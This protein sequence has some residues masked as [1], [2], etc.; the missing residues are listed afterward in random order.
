M[1]VAEG[2]ASLP[3]LH[4]VAGVL[5]DAEDRVLIAERPAGKAFAGRWEFPGGKCQAHETPL[6][7]LRRELAEELGIDADGCAPLMTVTHQYPG[8]LV[9]TRIDCWTVSSWRGTPVPLDGQGLRWCPRE[10]LGAA[11]I[12]EADRPIVTAL[13][14][15]GLFVRVPG[16]EAALSAQLRAAPAARVAWVVDAP[17]SDA[18][19]RAAVQARGDQLYGLDA[20]AGAGLDGII[21]GAVA[22]GW[23]AAPGALA[24]CVVADPLEAGAAAAA[25]M[26]FLLVPGADVA[27]IAAAAIA[28]LGLPWYAQAP[29]VAPAATGRLHWPPPAAGSD[30]GLGRTR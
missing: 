10:A 18:G 15:P 16:G 28:A 11:D 9:V 27:P 20:G 19:L 25:G 22:G 14:L 26:D 5:V 17:P 13:R 12:L 3:V 2:P 7:A 29:E 21:H 30:E 6:E 8:A 4:V 23:R 1:T 24:G